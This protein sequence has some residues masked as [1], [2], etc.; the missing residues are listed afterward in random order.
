MGCVVRPVAEAEL[1]AV[2]ALHR[3]SILALCATHYA[4]DALAAWTDALRPEGYRALFESR[5]FLVAVDGEE[6]VGFGV[7]EPTEALLHACYVRPS[8]AHRGVG[9]ALVAEMERTAR[10]RGA[11]SVRLNATDNAVG[12]YE[13]LGY[14]RGQRC[15]NRLPSG[16]ELS[17][18][19]MQ[20]PL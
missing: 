1:P 18:V 15:A 19:S 4:P 20:K 12:F 17:C 6:L 10:E 16:V 14:A 11:S 7:I 3:A 9:R 2:A 8:V 13:A 5:V